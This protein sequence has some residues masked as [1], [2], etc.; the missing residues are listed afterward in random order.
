M[1]IGCMRACSIVLMF[2]ALCFPM[3]GGSVIPVELKK[4]ERADAVSPEL[5]WAD[6]EKN[7]DSPWMKRPVEGLK[8]CLQYGRTLVE[9]SDD[10]SHR[11]ISCLEAHSG[12]WKTR[13]NK[14]EPGR[15]DDIAYEG[16]VYVYKDRE[17]YRAYTLSTDGLIW[18]SL[19]DA[20]QHV[21][22]SDL[23]ELREI[24]ARYEKIARDKEADEIGPCFLRTPE[25]RGAETLKKFPYGYDC[26]APN[27]APE[28]DMTRTIILSEKDLPF[29]LSSLIAADWEALRKQAS[30]NV[31]DTPPK[32]SK[33]AGRLR[34][35]PISGKGMVWR[36]PGAFDYGKD[37]D[38]PC[39]HPMYNLRYDIQYQEQSFTLYAS[40][41][42]AGDGCLIV[43]YAGIFRAS[44]TLPAYKGFF[45]AAGSDAVRGIS[46]FMDRVVI[47]DVDGDG[48]VDI[49]ILSAGADAAH[50]ESYNL[51]LIQ[52]R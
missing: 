8:A 35:Y 19:S 11:L 42:A 32:A 44:F 26:Y 31:R 41:N 37:W 43:P 27:Y 23:P 12:D 52:H 34:T 16:T 6:T 22:K 18:I 45:I 47:K 15:I 49:G 38:A 51:Q 5:R 36:N 13:F 20:E 24:Y 7:A 4:G 1:Y 25:H 9:L 2:F 30:Q 29:R 14:E 40:A 10:D 39:N 28:A 48:Y 46:P 3:E 50:A 21:L 33:S 17:L